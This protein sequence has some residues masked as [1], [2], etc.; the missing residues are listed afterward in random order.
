M[1]LSYLN[2]T[3]T[4]PSWNLA[5][6]QYVFDCLPRDRMYFMLWQNDNAIIIGKYQNA[7]AEIDPIV[8]QA[9]GIRVV[10][11]LSG[12]GAVYHDL[13][14]LN[15][16]F[17]SD[18]VS[19]DELDF[20]HFCRPIV[21][22]LQALGIPAG[23]NGRNDITIEGK[24]CSGNAQYL[25]EGRVMHHGTILFQSNLSI[26]SQALQVDP[27]KIQGNGIRS[28]RSRVTNV[29]D[30]LSQK[31]TLQAFRANLLDHIVHEYAGEE[32]V[33]TPDDLSHIQVICQTR[34]STWDWNYGFSPSCTLHKSRR[35]KGCGLVEAYLMIQHGLISNITF[36]GDFFSSADPQTLAKRFI[37]CRPDYEGLLSALDGVDVSRYFMG[38]NNA[39]LLDILLEN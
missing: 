2:M 23:V 16:T 38:L 20:Q 5:A 35:V 36:C 37:G 17:I 32:Y 29:A 6:E 22:T 19:G 13:G 21:H 10:R 24:K 26:M 11:R 12:G 28:V 8:V 18:A 27:Q 4:D 14:N 30:H 1:K 25:R 31:M 3:T 9:L 7:L 34:Y 33:L 15:F 39:K